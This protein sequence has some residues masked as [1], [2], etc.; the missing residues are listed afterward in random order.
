MFAKS[1][2][3]ALV[4]AVATVTAV[5]SFSDKGL[6][7]FA[8]NLE[9]LESALF[10]G[11]LSKYKTND[12][13]N[14][15]YPAWVRGRFQQIADNE[16]AH[17]KFLS[18]EIGSGAA[19]A[20]T[21]KFAYNDVKSLVNLAQKIESVGASTYLGLAR[22]I[23]DSSTLNA[24]AAI[25]ASASRQAGWITSSVLKDQPWDGPFETPLPPSAAW[26]IISTYIDDCP[27]SNPELPLID[28]PPLKVSDSTPKA[29]QTITLTFTLK[30]AK[31]P[32]Y[33]V[34]VDGL[35]YVYTEINA[36]KTKVPAGLTGTA[37]VGIVSSK[38]HPDRENFVTGFAVVEFPFD[39]NAR[40]VE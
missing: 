5:P 31:S 32:L 19:K 6:L 30:S 27:N 38:N 18:E 22:H 11:G 14:A 34:W 12:F 15:G 26:S 10:T 37:Y 29:G 17:V 39:S 4:G 8:L 40:N 23:N 13:V 20:C 21:Y 9:H 36:G 25:A 35:K 33:A 16:A 24:G 2:L 1:T 7:Q 3:V 28:L